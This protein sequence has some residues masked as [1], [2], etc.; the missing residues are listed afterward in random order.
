MVAYL[1]KP[2]G[3]EGFHQIVDFLNASHI[4]Y[5]LT[6]NPTIRHLQLADSRVLVVQGEGSTH[7]VESHHTPTNAPSTSQPPISL[8]FRRTNPR[9]EYVLEAG[10]SSVT[11]NKTPNIPMIHHSKSLTHLEVRKVAR[12]IISTIAVVAVTTASVAVVSTA[13]PTRR[14][15]TA[16]DITMAETLVYIRKSVAKDKGY[17]QMR[18]N[19]FVPIESEVDRAV[20][21][22]AVGISKRD[23]EVELDQESSKRQKT[24]KSSELAEEPKDKEEELS[25]EELQ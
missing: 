2:E 15:S 21:E 4:G 20:P 22:L 3:S 13:S 1:K 18:V 11:L 8:T 6:E 7:P 24:A 9:Q 19:T 25:Q 16:D 17:K 5:A 14:V 12:E 23:V 10:Q